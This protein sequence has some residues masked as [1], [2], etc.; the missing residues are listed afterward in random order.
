MTAL[1]PAG[2][3]FAGETCLPPQ[4]G[5]QSGTIGGMS[6]NHA[7][8][9]DW[10]AVLVFASVLAVAGILV[11]W[12]L[13][14]SY[15]SL[16]QLAARH[17]VPSPRFFPVGV[18]GALIGFLVLDVALTMWGRAVGVL[19]QVVRLFCG[20]SIW[21]NFRAGWP[22][23]VG[24][25]ARVMAPLLIVVLSEVVRVV[26][27]RGQRQG[28]PVPFRRWLLAPV[29]TFRLWRNMIL[30]G[31]SDYEQAL[32]TA[33]AYGHAIE[34]LRMWAGKRDW[35]EAAPADV[36][37]CLDRNVRVGETLEKVRE[38]TAPAP[39]L[40]PVSLGATGRR[41]SPASKRSASKRRA[42]A[43]GATIDSQVQALAE[44]QAHRAEYDSG[45]R[46]GSDMAAALGLSKSR[47]RTLLAGV[48]QPAPDTGDIAVVRG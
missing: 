35:R 41:Q 32:D 3:T 19:H 44:Y 48:R 5:E 11:G 28:H 30:W 37:W 8:R 36:V 14:G 29:L 12:G 20:A 47:A 34:Q 25:S 6:P 13:A 18:D 1:L 42:G 24:A 16:S 26:I 15:Q 7:R 22:D 39:A 46:N 9:R 23:T 38:L 17:G 21:F 27:I 33:I 10:R 2:E 40:T 4:N 31:I 45:E 43:S